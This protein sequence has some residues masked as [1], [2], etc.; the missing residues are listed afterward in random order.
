MNLKWRRTTTTLHEAH[1]LQW[2]LVVLAKFLPISR[3]D[4]VIATSLSKQFGKACVAPA[5]VSGSLLT[6][7]DR[8]EGGSES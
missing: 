4:W 2:V 1:I 3:R 5:G 7:R 6:L 8:G